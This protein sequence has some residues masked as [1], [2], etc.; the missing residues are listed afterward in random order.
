[1]Y[2]ASDLRKGL[3]IEIDNEPYVITD[4]DFCKPGKGQALYRC[5]LKNMVT[6]TTMDKTFRSVDKIDKPDLEQRDMI[7]SYKEATHYVFMDA[8]TYEQVLV[9]ANVLGDTQHFLKPDAECAILFYR[10]KPIDVDLPVF[11]EFKI[12]KTEPGVRGDTATNV[13]KP[14]QLENGYE[15]QVPIFLNE[16]D[17]IKV[18]TRT[19]EYS[20]RVSKA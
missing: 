14:A 4:F 18:D 7:Y 12:A 20:E 17:R 6:G 2:Q 9:P 13:T 15:L 10:D 19:G 1:M 8:E 16:G 5:K 3:K 11:V